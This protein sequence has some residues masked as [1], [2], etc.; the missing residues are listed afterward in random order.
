MKILITSD[1][2]YPVVNGVVRSVLN[3]KEYLENQGH[4]VRV[5]TLSNTIS[6]YKTKQVYYIGSLSAK[7]NL[8]PSSYY[9]YFGK[10]SFEK[11]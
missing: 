1:W 9:K 10:N 5:L 11:Y 7:K 8:S 4:E 6:S 2:Y 3:L